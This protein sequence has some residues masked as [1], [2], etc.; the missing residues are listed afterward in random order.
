[1]ARADLWADPASGLPLR[2]ELT[3]RGR[4]D[5][6]VTSAFLDLELG[7][8]DPASVRFAVPA[9]ADVQHNQAPDLARAIDRFSPFVLPDRLDGRARRT[10]VASAASTYGRG[11]ELV[12]VVAFPAQFSSRTRDFLERAPTR[13]GAWGEASVI[14]TPLLNGMIFERQGVAYA[15]A[16]TV[17]QQVLDQVA[18]DLAQARVT[19]R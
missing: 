8:P 6:I 5:P 19:P 4:L 7:P 10:E 17:T 14:A 12:A 13:A 3:P 18:A 16:G 9:D 11:F 1:V 2:V 15:L